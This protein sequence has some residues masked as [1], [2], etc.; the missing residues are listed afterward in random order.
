MQM[1]HFAFRGSLP[2]FLSPELL[3]SLLH[4]CTD[5]ISGSV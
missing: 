4:Y 1:S 5:D 3:S 2:L